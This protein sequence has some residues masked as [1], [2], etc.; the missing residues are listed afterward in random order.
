MYSKKK[1]A[2]RKRKEKKDYYT[3]HKKVNDNK[4]IKTTKPLRSEK[5]VSAWQCGNSIN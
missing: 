2:F 3:R 5:I 1:T 4:T